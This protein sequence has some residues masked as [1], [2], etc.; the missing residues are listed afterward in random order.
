MPS[1]TIAQTKSSEMNEKIVTPSPPVE[2]Y[3]YKPG[4]GWVSLKDIA[5]MRDE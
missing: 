5:F 4:Y 3:R 2:E 1:T